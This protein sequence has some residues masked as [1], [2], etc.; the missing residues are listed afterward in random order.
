MISKDYADRFP[1]L[2]TV[3]MGQGYD[4]YIGNNF[5]RKYGPIL[6]VYG[7]P[8]ATWEESRKLDIGVEIG[9]F[10]SLN[11]IFDWFKEKRSGIFMQRT[12]LPSTFGMSGITPWANIGKVDNSGVDI[13]V[14]YNKAFSKDLILSLRGTFTYA[15]NEIVGN[16]RTQIQMGLPVQGRTSDQLDPMPDRRRAFQGRGRDRLLALAGHL[17]HDLPHPPGRREIPRP[18]R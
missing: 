6:S 1:Y 13:S 8:N 12:S 15:H 5:E 18:E 9:L 14:D 17:R 2:T 4:V 10:D 16:G 3:D 7:N 11:I